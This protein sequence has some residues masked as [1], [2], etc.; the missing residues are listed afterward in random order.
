MT[1]SSITYN[2]GD[3]VLVAFPFS[4]QKTTK[5][6]PA[7]I[8][9]APWFNNRGQDVIMVGIT[10][11]IHTPLDKDELLLDNDDLHHGG[12]SLECIVSAGQIAR[13]EKKLIIRKIGFIRHKTVEAVIQ[14]LLNVCTQT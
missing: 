14:H 2:Q 1:P 6:R 13:I 11:T 7:L 9:S 5:P 8:I 12:L 4:D 3:I 10:T